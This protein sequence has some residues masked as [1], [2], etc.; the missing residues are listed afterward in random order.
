MKD[1]IAA[2]LSRKTGCPVKIVNT[3]EEEFCT[4]RIRYPMKIS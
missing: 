2:I 3:R 1:P 4:H